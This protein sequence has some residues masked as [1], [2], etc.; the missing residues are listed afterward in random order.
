MFHPL[1]LNMST[2]SVALLGNKPSPV[3]KGQHLIALYRSHPTLGIANP[4]RNCNHPDFV[5]GAR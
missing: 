2:P 1:R 4:T 5:G 3:N